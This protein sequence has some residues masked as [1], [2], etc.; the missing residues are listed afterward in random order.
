MDV[1][2]GESC[3]LTLDYAYYHVL[4]C[5]LQVF[6]L[7]ANKQTRFF[8]ISHAFG[9]F[10]LVMDYGIMYMTNGKRQISYP[11]LADNLDRGPNSGDEPMGPVGVFL[12]FIWFDYSAFGIIAWALEVE[13]YFRNYMNSGLA[14][15]VCVICCDSTRVFNLLIVPLQFWTA[16]WLSPALGLDA[17]TIILTRISSK[18]QYACMVIAFSLMLRYGA[19]LEWKTGI[20]PILLSG[21]SCGLVHHAA[22]FTFGMR[23]YSDPLSLTITL[24]TEWPALIAGVAVVKLL[25]WQWVVSAFPFLSLDITSLELTSQSENIFRHHSPAGRG[26]KLFTLSMW[27]ALAGLL[28]PH[29]AAV[30]DKDAVAY[31]IPLIS[32][33]H[34]QTAGTA[35]MRLRT[36]IL[37]RYAL[38]V[39]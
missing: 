32:G 27:V 39:S 8:R 34:M 6:I 22:L 11:F 17:R 23:G 28:Y 13:E 4:F 10:A 37:P 33:E 36:C 35:F 19:N 15:T 18:A 14:D 21:F 16:P 31:L 5:A 9:L 25:F 3:K 2:T 24:A 7:L 12:F 29:L 30:D 38:Y 26:T 1:L 20:L